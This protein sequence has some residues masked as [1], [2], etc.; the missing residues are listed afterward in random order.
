MAGEPGPWVSPE[1][2]ELI[3]R[4]KFFHELAWK[5][6]SRGKRLLQRLARYRCG[7]DY[8]RWPVEMLFTP[9]AGSGSKALMISQ[10]P[11]LSAACSTRIRR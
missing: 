9:M 10:N 7:R 6:A 8:Y 4:F 3:E 2:F 5:R 11:I 1:K